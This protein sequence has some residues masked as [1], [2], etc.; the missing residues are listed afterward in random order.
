[1]LSCVKYTDFDNNI[2]IDSSSGDI[3]I[4]LP[5]DSNFELDSETSSGRII[6]DYPITISGGQDR[7]QLEGIVGSGVNKIHLEVSSGDI[8]ILRG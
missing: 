6:C 8:S 7:N 2:A 5:A 3:K 1:M 4:T